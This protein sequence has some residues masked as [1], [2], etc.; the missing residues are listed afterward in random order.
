MN[1]YIVFKNE[2]CSIEMFAI[3]LMLTERYEM[4]CIIYLDSSEK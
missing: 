2:F 1:P 4:H 3:V